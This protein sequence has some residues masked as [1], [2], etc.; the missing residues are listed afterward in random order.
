MPVAVDS[1]QEV[2]VYARLR[3]FMTEIMLASSCG[4]IAK[5][6][7]VQGTL[8]SPKL[9]VTGRGHRLGSLKRGQ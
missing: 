4:S 7:A 2:H 5:E 3:L 1:W 9:P 8:E 6:V